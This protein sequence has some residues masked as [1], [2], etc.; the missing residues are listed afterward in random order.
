MEL[1]HLRYFLAVADSLSFTRAAAGL[2]LTQPTLSQ[3]IKQLE[4][5]LGTVL[6]DRVGR[7]VQLTAPGAIFRQHAERALKEIHSATE[8]L[9]ELEGLMRG[10]L[11]IGVFQ[12][13]NSSL[14]PP[15]LAEFSATYP[16]VGVIVRQLPTGEMEDRLVKGELDLGIAYEP[17]NSDQIIAEK[18]FDEPLMLVVG[19]RHPYA[20]RREIHIRELRDQ[21]LIL[22]TPEFP[23]RKLLAECFAS[24]GYRPRIKIEINS[25][26]AILATVKC[27]RL[28]TIQTERMAKAFPGLHCIRLK[29]ELTRT[30]AIFWRREGYRPAAA[31]AAAEIIKQAYSRGQ[32]H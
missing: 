20:K 27:S 12:S 32:T 2:H 13:F 29:P 17:P 6:F 15:I 16:G 24:V 8:A 18:L 21:P 1:R 10:T 5:H 22:L 3:Q 19:S 23:S 30:V 26:D 4:S 9:A 25:T 31:R 28:A 14:L 7:K 11:T